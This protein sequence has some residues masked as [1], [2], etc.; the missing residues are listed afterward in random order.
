MVLNEHSVDSLTVFSPEGKLLNI[1][2]YEDFRRRLHDLIDSGMT[3]AV[4]DM[5]KVDLVNSTG[6]SMLI[7]GLKI[8]REAGG[9]L[10]LANL[11]GVAYKVIV[12]ICGLGRVFEI[13]DSVD[14]AVASFQAQ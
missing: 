4:F 10:R 11:T 3:G 5:G 9:D 7:A 13:Y 14:E 12:T 2:Q 6:V 8:L 1:M